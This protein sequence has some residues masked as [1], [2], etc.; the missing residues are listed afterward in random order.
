MGGEFEELYAKR[1]GSGF[2]RFLVVGLAAVVLPIPEIGRAK[3][4]E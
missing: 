2:V 3:P 1:R 4:L